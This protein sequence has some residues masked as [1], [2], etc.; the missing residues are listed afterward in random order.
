WVAREQLQL[1]KRIQNDPRWLQFLDVTEDSFGCLAEFHLGRMEHR[2]L[3]GVLEDFLCGHELTHENTIERP[4]MRDGDGTRLFFAF[5]QR[6]VQN[7][8]A[9][10]HAF[11]Q[12][13]KGQCGLSRTGHAF[14]YVQ[15]V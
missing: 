14:Y 6:N 5:G 15:T 3:L 12:E 9:A 11:A 1:G 4:S 7:G 2:I 13:L 8:L 10:A